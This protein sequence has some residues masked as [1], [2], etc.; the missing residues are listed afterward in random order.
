MPSRKPQPNT[1][2]DKKRS[3]APDF[4]LLRAGCR[5][6]A[7]TDWRYKLSVIAHSNIPT[8]NSID[9]FFL[10]QDK[11]QL[12]GKLLAVKKRLGGFNNF[13]IVNQ[14]CYS[15]WVAATFPP[16]FP[17]VAKVGTASGGLGKMKILDSDM[18]D[19]FR[20]LMPMQNQFFATEGFI[21]WD[22]DIRIQKIGNHYRAFRRTAKHWKSNVDFAMK[23]EDIEVEER[24]KIWIEEAAHELGM[25]ICAMDVLQVAATGKEYI[26][27][28]NSSAIG[29]NGRHAEEDNKHIRDLVLRKME[30]ARNLKREQ[31]TLRDETIKKKREEHNKEEST[32]KENTMEAEDKAEKGKGKEK[33]EK[34]VQ[35]E[36]EEATELVPSYESLLR[37]VQELQAE[38]KQMQEAKVAKEKEE[39]EKA[40]KKAEEKEKKGG[41]FG[42][43]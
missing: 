39:Q 4:I 12:Y 35:K 23:D 37:Q 10:S 36:K 6:D 18:W 20:S 8:L 31:D 13:P 21:P 26:L 3:F 2:Q 40:D 17:C 1:P 15:D 34:K 19:D 41:F 25:E 16:D 11:G 30:A 28:C 42:R 5:G 14:G 32:K 9:S 38:L 24:Y 43:K 7:K 29:L 27:E 33:K 22:Y